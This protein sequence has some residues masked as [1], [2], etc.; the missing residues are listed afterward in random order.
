MDLSGIEWIFDN[1]SHVAVM[2]L[3][4]IFQPELRKIFERAVS[5]RRAKVDDTGEELSGLIADSLLELSQKRRGA[6]IV[7]PGRESIREWLSGGFQLDAAPSFPLFMSIFDPNSP[8]HDGALIVRDGRFFSF[9]VRLPV[10]Q[11][12]RLS[13]AYGTR[14]H[15]AMGLSEKSATAVPSAEATNRGVG[16]N[17]RTTNQFRAGLVMVSLR[18]AALAMKAEKYFATLNLRRR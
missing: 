18:I 11:S 2:G 3:I 15:A 4:V 8:G 6:L 14:H 9:G 5:V 7:F 13:E 12:H 1:L 17:A 16:G 10:S